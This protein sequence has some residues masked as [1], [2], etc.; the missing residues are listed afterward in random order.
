MICGKESFAE[1]PE[2]VDLFVTVTHYICY[3]LRWYRILCFFASLQQN[4][5]Y[6]CVCM[7]VCKNCTTTD[8]WLHLL[9][10][11]Y[12]SYKIL[13]TLKYLENCSLKIAFLNILQLEIDY[14]V[15]GKL[16]Q[17]CLCLKQQVIHLLSAIRKSSRQ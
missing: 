9:V 3:E 8:P 15:V 6:T 10:K 14:K 11:Y 1:T 5:V 13:F 7:H 16:R 12:F 4:S 17:T 2:N